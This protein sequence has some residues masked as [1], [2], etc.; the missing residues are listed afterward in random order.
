M[1][2]YYSFY[3]KFLSKKKANELYK[4]IIE[5]V[6]FIQHQVIV[7]DKVLNEP[8]LSVFYA[9]DSISGYNYSG[10]KREVFPWTTEMLNVKLQVEAFLSEK[11]GRP[12]MFNSC[13]CNYYRNGKDY[14]CYHSD[15]ES[16]LV[17]GPNGET[18]IASLSIGATRK[19]RLRKNGQ[20]SGYDK[21]FSLESG[22]LLLMK[23][24]CQKI[25]KHHVPKE[26]KVE[27]GRIN[28][29]FRMLDPKKIK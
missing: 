9:D 8:R 22:S 15:D 1:N 4:S 6:E 17:Q 25:Y 27:E 29:T 12:I 26:L 20:T 5:N 18:D 14:I 23:G 24:K 3:P 16:D 2:Q 19:F 13:L 7:F 11:E 10:S 28:L 21:E